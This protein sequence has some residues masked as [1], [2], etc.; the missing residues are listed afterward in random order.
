MSLARLAADEMPDAFYSL[1]PLSFLAL[2]ALS[3]GVIPWVVSRVL[4]CPFGRVLW[5][6]CISNFL[7]SAVLFSISFCFGTALHIAGLSADHVRSSLVWR[8]QDASLPKNPPPLAIR[9]RQEEVAGEAQ[10]TLENIQQL[11]VVAETLARRPDYRVVLTELEPVTE[12][13][14]SRIERMGY[15]PAL[16]AVV[17]LNNRNLRDRQVSLKCKVPTADI[18]GRWRNNTVLFVDQLDRLPTD[19]KEVFAAVRVIF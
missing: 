9:L 7:S 2:C 13:A 4:N 3:W 15:L 1:L 18:T 10:L 12:H 16:H 11:K 5:T 19:C 8:Y 14:D 6:S 17:W